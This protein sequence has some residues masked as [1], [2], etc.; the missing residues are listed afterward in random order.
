MRAEHAAV[1][2]HF[3]KH[4]IA[5]PAQEV[6]PLPVV[7]QNSVV[8]HIRGGEHKISVFAHPPPLLRRGVAV[9]G[10]GVEHGKMIGGDGVELVG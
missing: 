3:V 7:A 6:C 2:V 1:A 10:G 5:Q 9:I 4:H 8:E